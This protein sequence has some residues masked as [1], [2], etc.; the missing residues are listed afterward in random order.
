MRKSKLKKIMRIPL[1]T[2]LTVICAW[3]QIPISPPIT[4]QLLGVFLSL[5]LLGGYHGTVSVLLYIALGAIGLPV[6]SGFCGGVGHIFGIGGGF[7]I[8]FIL[9]ALIYLVLEKLIG[10]DGIRLVIILIIA[11]AAVYICGALWYAFVYTGGGF[12]AI[13]AAF[14]VTVLP[15]VLPDA[16]KIFLTV[17]ITSRVKRHIYKNNG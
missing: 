17:L 3:I 11:T 14:A 6:F 12:G 2:A 8:G 15:F 16:I 5:T 7:I 1:M 10:T 13:A 4:L 9:S